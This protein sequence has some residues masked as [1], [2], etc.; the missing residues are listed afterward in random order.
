MLANKDKIQRLLLIE[1]NYSK[2]KNNKAFVGTVNL[3]LV[4]N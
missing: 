2:K 1:P 4:G 3:L